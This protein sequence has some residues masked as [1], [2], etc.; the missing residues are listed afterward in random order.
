MIHILTVIGTVIFAQNQTTCT[1]GGD[2]WCPSDSTCISSSLLCDGNID[3]SDLLDE[4][5]SVCNSTICE[6]GG[7]VW[8]SSDQK[9]IHKDV[10]C[11][12]F[13]NCADS[14]EDEITPHCDST[15]FAEKG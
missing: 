13:P 12:G 10:A 11:N 15:I 6:T 2:Y 9:C 1:T 7:N 14:Y 4:K 8:C 5:P 3:C